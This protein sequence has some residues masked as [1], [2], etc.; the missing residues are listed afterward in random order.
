[1][2]VIDVNMGNAQISGDNEVQIFAINREAAREIFR[3]FR[4]RGTGGIIIIDF[5]NMINK[6][7]IKSLLQFIDELILS[8]PMPLQ[9]GNISSLGLLEISRKSR[10]Q[11]LDSY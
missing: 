9:R 2:T 6:G 1:M 11:D 5:I 7:N 10:Q 4:L 8:D 3:Q